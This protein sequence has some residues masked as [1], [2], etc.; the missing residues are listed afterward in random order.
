MCVCV[1]DSGDLLLLLLMK[2]AAGDG[3]AVQ[4]RRETSQW[5][6]DWWLV[7]VGLLKA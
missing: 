1:V 2:R 7:G 3:D 5:G 4:N 6:G